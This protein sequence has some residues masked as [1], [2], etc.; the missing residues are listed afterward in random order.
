MLFPDAFGLIA[1]VSIVLQGLELLTDVGIGASIVQNKRG[2][3][4][5]FLNT[6]W[7]IHVIRGVGIFICACLIAY[8]MGVFYGEPELISIIAVMSVTGL[9]S[10]FNSMAVLL[11]SRKLWVGRATVMAL[12][13]RA[14]SICVMVVWAY[15]SPTVWV[16]VGGNIVSA[17]LTAILSHMIFPWW[18]MKFQWDAQAAREIVRFGKWM[19]LTS[20]LAFFA[21]QIDRLTLAKLVPLTLVGIYS[22]GFMWATLPLQL[23]QAWTG[24]VLFPFASD[25]LRDPQGDR[26]RLRRYRRR[27]VWLSAIG[28]GAFGGIATPAM[29]LLYTPTYWPAADFLS[30]ILIG[31]AAKMLDDLYR[32]LNLA[33][34]Q[35]KYTSAGSAASLLLFIAAVYPLYGLYGAHGVAIAFSISQIGTLAASAYGA[36]RAGLADL[37]SDMAAVLAGVGVWAALYFATWSLL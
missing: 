10:G 18:R 6:A 19:L 20:A 22:I 13:I 3:D 37:G 23:L 4:P 9:I 2:E 27:V 11:A 35:P 16:F 30:L 34:G 32:P 1:L 29:H 7:T 15:L 31:T 8:P 14:A 5:A 36:R 25:T 17:I 24:R 21:S 26:L 33:L 12:A 28:I